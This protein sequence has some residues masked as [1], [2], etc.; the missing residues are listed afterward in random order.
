[1]E[2]SSDNSPEERFAE[3]QRR[4]GKQCRALDDL[5]WGA[6]TDFIGAIPSAI[7]RVDFLSFVSKLPDGGVANGFVVDP[8][9]HRRN[10]DS[11]LRPLAAERS[12][13]LSEHFNLERILRTAERITNHLDAVAYLRST[14]D[15]YIDYHPTIRQGSHSPEELRFRKTL[16]SKI[17]VRKDLHAASAQADSKAAANKETAAHATELY[18]K[19]GDL[20]RREGEMDADNARLIIELADDAIK[21]LGT[22]NHE[23]KVELRRWKSEAEA[24][25][26]PTTVK[27]LGERAQ[28]LLLKKTYP[29][30]ISWRNAL[31]IAV[32]IVTVVIYLTTPLKRYFRPP[33]S[34]VSNQTIAPAVPSPTTTPN[35][36]P[37]PSADAVQREKTRL[38]P[39]RSVNCLDPPTTAIL[40]YWPVTYEVDKEACHDYPSVDARLVGEEHFSR[41]QEEW[42]RGLAAKPG[43]E[44]VVLL[45]INNGAV[46]N[47]EEISPGRGIARNVRLTTEVGQETGE[48]HYV[49]VRFAG[50]NT[51]TVINRF[52]ITTEPSA[53][54][55]VVPGSGETYTATPR[56]LVKNGLDI[57]NNTIAIGDIPPRWSDS[58]FARFR[59][60]VVT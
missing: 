3:Y 41:S 42:E 47:A 46:N 50:D 2:E 8:P 20:I 49:N 32:I 59:I 39:P 52:K 35:R 31:L 30:K 11:L 57:D 24:A 56:A 21:E 19:V 51:N 60:K 38:D 10:Q 48:I 6:L 43:D 55:E 36:Q 28:G 12:R 7:E 13:L 26:P 53:R 4:L 15:R 54:L 25:L 18:E 33:R 14:L 23:K 5:D 58:V 27:E 40:N 1:M 22:T 37:Q 45:Y 16:E 29:K 44:I 9:R 17:E 34:G